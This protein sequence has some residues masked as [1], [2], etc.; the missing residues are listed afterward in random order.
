MEQSP[1]WEAKNFWAT[2]EISSILWNRNFHY[3]I[4]KCPLPVLVLSQIKPIY[5][6]HTTSLRSILIL[7]SHLRLGFP[8]S[9]FASGYPAKTLY[10]PFLSSICVTW[11]AHL[12]L[13]DLITRIISGEEYRSLSSSLCSFLY[14][15]VTSTL[16]GPNIF[17]STLFSNT[18]SLRSPRNMSGTCVYTRGSSG[19]SMKLTAHLYTL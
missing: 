16:L 11:A 7:S 2:Q 13:L 4:Y 3:R 1:S 9:L 14:S 8:S 15:L 19:R 12:I 18:L 6:S 10:I 17:L 5:D